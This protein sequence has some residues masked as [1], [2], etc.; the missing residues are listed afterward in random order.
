MKDKMD[1]RLFL[2]LNT[3]WHN[4]FKSG[5]KKWEL[6]GINGRFNASDIYEGR[7]VELRRGY[8]YDPLWG[9]I[10]DVLLVTR[11]DEIPHRIYN[12]IV[13]E[14]VQ[15]DPD[16]TKFLKLYENKYNCFILFKIDIWR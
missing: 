7:I 16:I 11:F 8:K 12:L 2:P 13:P 4:L 15:N 9:V 1:T 10:T 14:S 3:I 6:R 5:E